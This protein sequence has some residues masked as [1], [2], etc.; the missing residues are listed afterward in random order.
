MDIENVKTAQPTNLSELLSMYTN[1]K[2][3]GSDGTPYLGVEQN[4]GKLVYGKEKRGLPEGNW[5]VLSDSRVWGWS[6]WENNKKNSHT[7]PYVEGE[8]PPAR[9]IGDA[10]WKLEFGW[11]MR[12]LNDPSLVISYSANNSTAH[13]GFEK[14]TEA[15]NRRQLPE[16]SN[17]VIRMFTSTFPAF[18]RTHFKINFPIVDWVNP[19]SNQLLSDYKAVG[20]A[21]ETPANDDIHTEVSERAQRRT[22]A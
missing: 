7:E 9:P 18:G 8:A 5:E 14:L 1:R 13:D 10:D 22:K 3:G 15:C 4:S 6:F 19:S 2:K 12:S 20:A 16:F 11:K 21:T 17:P